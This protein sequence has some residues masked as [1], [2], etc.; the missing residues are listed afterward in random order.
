MFKLFPLKFKEYPYI[1]IKIWEWCPASCTDCRFNLD[2]IV[3]T[4]QFSLENILK[5]INE[6]DKKFDKKFNLVFW[7]QD[8]LNHNNIISIL[9]AWLD[10]GREI[11]F[12]IDFDIKKE[13]VILL[14]KIEKE[15]WS[16]KIDIKIAKNARVVVSNL[17]EKPLVLIKLLSQ[18]TNFKVFI[19]LFLDFTDHKNLV[20][21]FNTK[22]GDS[23]S[24]NK[25][26]FNIWKN[27]NLKFHNYSWYL[28]RKNKCFIN[29]KREECQ[30]LSQLYIKWWDIFLKDSL[31]VYENWDLFI[32]D[33][34]CNIWDIRISNL[35]LNDNEIYNH[36]DLYLKYLNKLKLDNNN[37]AD[38]CFDCINNWF[39]YKKNSLW[40]K[41]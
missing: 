38:M 25:F 9:K 6:V 29:L 36:F 7:N 13:H 2:Y 17:S 3:K 10:T 12:Q 32:H 22:F 14:E 19:D 21:T 30:Q 20:N 26:D 11:R 34:L 5:R 40:E 31:D 27:I 33:N 37:Q 18:K 41:C 23:F 24:D 4:K 8:G 1:D 15:L 35:Y 28:D 39:K 16:K